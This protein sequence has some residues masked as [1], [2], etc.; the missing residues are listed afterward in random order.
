MQFN[1]TERGEARRP[2]RQLVF[3]D[4]GG[5]EEA[6]GGV[7]N[8]EEKI[9]VAAVV[10][11]F[12]LLLADSLP[13]QWGSFVN[14][15]GGGGIPPSVRRI[16]ELKQPSCLGNR[17]SRG[18]TAGRPVCRSERRS[19]TAQHCVGDV[20]IAKEREREREREEEKEIER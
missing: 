19:A 8:K 7:K 16:S 9:S 12:G 11:P 17:L 2:T 14:G 13:P 10:R 15:D 20:N 3:H 5:A 18:E 4:C 6:S 1:C